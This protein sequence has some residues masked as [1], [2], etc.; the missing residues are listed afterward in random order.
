MRKAEISETELRELYVLRGLSSSVCAAHFGCSSQAV[1]NRLKAH[2]IQA[3]TNGKGKTEKVC[4]DCGRSFNVFT[5]LSAELARCPNCRGSNRWGN[6]DKRKD[7]ACA[8][9]GSL[10]RRLPCRLRPG[11]KAFCNC[12]CRNLWQSKNVTGTAHHQWTGGPKAKAARVMANPSKRLR[13]RIGNQIWWALHGR[14]GGRSWEKLVGY[15]LAELMVHLERQFSKGM[16]WTNYG[17]WHIDHIMPVVSF[18]F[19]DAHDPEFRAC[20]ALS[21]LRPLWA[22]ENIA[23]GAKILALI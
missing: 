6:A 14:K 15:S 9:C 17:A 10:L 13:A 22:T 2:G 18:R 16:T 5:S 21:N 1:L 20:F 3:H 7:V 19:K 8:E 12:E 23:K 11:Q 4:I